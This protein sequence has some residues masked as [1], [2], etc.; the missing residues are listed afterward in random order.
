MLYLRICSPNK[1][2]FLRI[3]SQNFDIQ[4]VCICQEIDAFYSHSVKSDC[5]SGFLHKLKVYFVKMFIFWLS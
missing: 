5:G 4:D 1:C 3:V 2:S